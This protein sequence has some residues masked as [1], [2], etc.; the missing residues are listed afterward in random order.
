MITFSKKLSSDWKDCNKKATSNN[1]IV[2]YN[3]RS[4]LDNVKKLKDHFLCILKL[5]Y[6]ET[7]PSKSLE[8][9]AEML[10]G[11]YSE[12]LKFDNIP[13]DKL[14]M[15]LN[16]IEKRHKTILYLINNGIISFKK[17]EVYWIDMLKHI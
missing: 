12:Q 10:F 13:E 5:K 11:G 6:E 1:L 4:F 9:I 14:Q 17:H 3:W 16:K 15:H 8:Y 2:G 7:T